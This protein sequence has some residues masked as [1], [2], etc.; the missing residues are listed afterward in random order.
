MFDIYEL[1]LENKIIFEDEHLSQNDY[2][3]IVSIG[4]RLEKFDWTKTFIEQYKND[5]TPEFRQNAYEYNLSS[6]YYSKHD[7]KNA[8]KLLQRV[9]FTDVFYHLGAKSMLLKM[10]YEL[11]EVEPFYSIIDAFKVY[12]GRNKQISANQRLSH[13]NLVKWT[14]RAF[15]IRIRGSSSKNYLKAVETLKQKINTGKNIAN[16]QWLQERIEEF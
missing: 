3:N 16:L 5:I 8:L 12:L 1:L 7:Y 13:Q 6:Y 11:E 15:D 9:E 14:K 10:Y 2:K 4:L